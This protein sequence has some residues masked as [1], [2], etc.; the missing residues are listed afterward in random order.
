MKLKKLS[1]NNSVDRINCFSRNQSFECLKLD[2]MW[3]QVDNESTHYWRKNSN[4]NTGM[5]MY[6][7]E[8]RNESYENDK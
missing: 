8:N 6:N 5:Y 7:N 4:L 3:P 2:I 1:K